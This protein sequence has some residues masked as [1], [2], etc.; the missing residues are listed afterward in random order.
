MGDVTV[1]DIL[2]DPSMFDGKRLAD[3][4]EPELGKGLAIFYAN[5]STGVPKIFSHVHGNI[6]YTFKRE[7][8]VAA[9]N[10]E[11]IEAVEGELME[12]FKLPDEDESWFNDTG[13]VKQVLMDAIGYGEL[14]VDIAVKEIAKV[15]HF[16]VTAL[17]KVAKT[18]EKTV[19]STGVD[20]FPDG[21][22]L[23][24]GTPKQTKP[25]IKA[26]ILDAGIKLRINTMSHEIEAVGIKTRSGNL[27]EAVISKVEDLAVKEEMPYG[28]IRNLVTQI[29]F[30]DTYHPF[31][32]YL[33]G[34]SVWDGK[35]HI[36]QLLDSLGYE[37]TSQDYATKSKMMI[38][39]W[40]VSVVAA[41]RRPSGSHSLRIV[42]VFS[43]EQHIGK[44]TWFKLLIPDTSMFKEGGDLNPSCKD[45]VA[46]N[47]KYLIT[48]LGEIDSVFDMRSIS[49]LK[50]FLSKEID[51]A[52][53]PYDRGTT[54]NPRKTVFCGTVNDEEYL[55]DRTGNTRFATIKV[56]TIDHA[57]YNAI[58]KNQLWAQI[59]DMFN[60]GERWTFNDKEIE[61]INERNAEHMDVSLIERMVHE[62][63]N[64]S[65]AK[66]GWK[67]KTIT[68]IVDSVGQLD[69]LARNSKARKEFVGELLKRT[70]VK[71]HTTLRTNIYLM[72][73]TIGV[74]VIKFNDFESLV[75]K[76]NES[77]QQE[78]SE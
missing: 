60:N 28:R 24:E 45:S 74:S 48:E 19:V 22:T 64:W 44:T 55:V 7:D 49:K 17:R 6:H 16:T 26:L 15:S 27:E 35:D 23:K 51:E 57:K 59:L 36:A 37:D 4:A 25:N 63:F 41:I 43:G 29:A 69:T 2:D 66:E 12:P 61:I 34:L 14:E 78:E 77:A 10:C 31:D 20:I 8:V 76:Q 30:D 50:A 75:E 54:K 1:Q 62:R 73:T 56:M 9:S 67:W 46:Q 3:P 11:S 32:E 39:R 18:L 5:I 42:L 52:R 47:T 13:N 53:L 38:V 72:P 68:E 65:E 58:D 40:L 70:K 33:K 21:R 71:K